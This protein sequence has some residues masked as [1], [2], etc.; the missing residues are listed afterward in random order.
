MLKL[1]AKKT[2]QGYV[3]LFLLLA[4]I[5]VSGWFV[6]PAFADSTPQYTS[7]LADLQQDSEFNADEYPDKPNDYSIQVIQIA[8]STDKELFVY[9]YQ[10]S[11]KTTYF[12][13]TDVNMSLTDSVEGTELYN[14]TLLNCDGVFC[15]YKVNDLTV[16]DD[17]V[18][19]YNITS[20]YREWQQG[21]DEET[22]NDN[23]KNEVAFAVGKLYKVTT[24][25]GEIVYRCE[26]CKTVEIKNPYV[27]YIR[28]SQGYG[29]H[30]K[31]CDSHYVAFSTNWKIDYLYEADLEYV[32]YAMKAFND[33]PD[34]S[35]FD[36]PIS[37]HVFYTDKDRFDV[38]EKDWLFGPTTEYSR[39]K[40]AQ[41]FLN[42]NDENIRGG[43]QNVIKDKEWVLRF[44]ETDYTS[45]KYGSDVTIT[46][47][48]YVTDVTILR[49]KFKSAGD[50]YNLGAV[51]PKITGNGLP[52]NPDPLDDISFWEYVWNCIVKLFNGTA[53][54]VETVVAVAAIFVV[55]ALLPILL[56]VLSLV[57]PAFGAVMKKILKGLLICIK[58]FFKGLLW[59][60]CLPFK[61]IVKIFSRNK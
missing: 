51:S 44:A 12:V 25:N 21:I 34:S 37:H 10:P 50:V 59:L 24:E 20:I 16:S 1:Q 40:S 14:L 43:I 11:Q 26:N 39:I 27:G 42:E 8:E 5:S 46:T 38:T 30:K 4:V 18:R 60:I 49:L 3:L 28:Y 61:G 33:L 13:A 47:Y 56:F 7:A 48:T 54:F 41:D 32:T 22:G 6:L 36:Q 52:S 15:K 23:T 29:W 19:Y 53:D 55:V 2:L 9:T 58:W 45:Q 35:G 17:T 31:A 57:F